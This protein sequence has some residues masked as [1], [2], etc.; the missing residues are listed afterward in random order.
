MTLLLNLPFVTL[1]AAY[2]YLIIVTTV[3]EG[4]VEWMWRKR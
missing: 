1:Q 4:V 3:A 2:C